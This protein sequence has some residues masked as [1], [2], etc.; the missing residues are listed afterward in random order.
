MKQQTFKTVFLLLFAALFAACSKDHTEPTTDPNSTQVEAGGL[1]CSITEADFNADTEINTRS[2]QPVATQTMEWSEGVEAEVS[3]ERDPAPALT[4]ATKPMSDGSYTIVAYKDG[5]RLDRKITFTVSHGTMTITSEKSRFSWVSKGATYTFVCFN[6][7]V[8]DNQ[9][10]T[11]TIPLIVR[12]M[13]LIGKQSITIGNSDETVKFTMKHVSARVRTKFIGLMTPLAVKTFL[14][15]QA[16]Q[17]PASTVYN[18]ATGA[19]TPSSTKSSETRMEEQSYNDYGTIPAPNFEEDEL[20]TVTGSE[21]LSVLAGTKPEELSY[22]IT[23]GSIYHKPFTSRG[24][25][26]FKATG[27]FEANGSYT[28]TIKLMPRYQYLFEDGKTGYLADADR[29]GHVAI[30]IVFDRGKA[31]SLW[32]A[33]GGNKA[34][35]E[36]AGKNDL[37]QRN[38]TIM[39]TLQLAATTKTSG[40]E[41]TWEEYDSYHNG[42]T[43]VKPNDPN[44]SAYQLA[45]KFY[46]SGDLL[47]R[48][49]GKTLASELNQDKAWYLPSLY[50]WCRVYNVLG[51]GSGAPTTVSGY[52]SGRTIERAFKAVGGS[53]VGTRYWSSSEHYSNNAYW[54]SISDNTSARYPTF[55]VSGPGYYSK[56]TEYHVRPF[57][58]FKTE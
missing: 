52:W 28:L 9:D 31:I 39:T 12:E 5:Q 22:E 8:T 4:R 3:L 27:A 14:G 49:G 18:Y 40:Y 51:F 50:E 44:F 43:V 11:F 47:S 46:T 54:A 55:S 45:G 33:N 1:K 41:W 19:F 16:N 10:G 34:K 57:V 20:R 56:Q 32:N 36:L 17:I 29:A 24:V 21:Y 53:L 37:K 2:T 58:Q 42:T 25:R 35:W 6:E 30:G 48:L 38:S 26:S 15:Y 7:H 23:R 13:A